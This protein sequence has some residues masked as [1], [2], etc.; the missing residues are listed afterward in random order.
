MALLITDPIDWELDDDN[1]VVIPLRYTRGLQAVEQ[2]IRI[3]LQMIK[4]EW[5][6]NLDFGIAW[7]E[8][9][10][11]PPEEAILGGQ[12]NKER[13]LNAVRTMILLT[14][15]VRRIKSLGI[16]FNDRTRLMNIVWQVTT[17]WGDTEPDSLER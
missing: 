2:G 16:T 10:T 13:A 4:G 8:N 14:P 12:F 7:M 15:G 11:V 1:D 17:E 6:L 3:R 5:F 9:E